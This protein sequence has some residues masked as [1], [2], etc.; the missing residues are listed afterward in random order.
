MRPRP[1]YDDG[2]AG[3]E[4]VAEVVAIGNHVRDRK[5]GIGLSMASRVEVVS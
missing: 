5:P 2:A 1:P 3:H 4:T